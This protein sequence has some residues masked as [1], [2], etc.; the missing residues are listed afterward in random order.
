MLDLSIIDGELVVDKRKFNR[1]RG[2]KYDITSYV[3]GITVIGIGEV[4][5]SDICQAH[6]PAGIRTE[7]PIATMCGSFLSSNLDYYSI[8]RFLK[9][10]NLA[11][12]SFTFIALNSRRK[13]GL[14]VTKNSPLTFNNGN[15]VSTGDKMHTM[16]WLIGVQNG[17]VDII[18]T[19]EIPFPQEISKGRLFIVED[20]GREIPTFNRELDRVCS[21][22]QLDFKYGKRL[23]KSIN[24]YYIILAALNIINLMADKPASII[25]P[26]ETRDL[27]LDN[28]LNLYRIVHSL[29]NGDIKLELPKYEQSIGTRIINTR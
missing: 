29:S 14:I 3:G 6:C 17:N 1:Y 16:A 19:I 25:L 4:L 18:D 15:L 13:K 22:R 12:G 23:D 10:L 24:Y 5:N 9:V 20:L 26:V 21:Y 27:E 11:E 7:H 8:E 28:A 2:S